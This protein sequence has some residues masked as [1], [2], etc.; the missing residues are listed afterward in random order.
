MAEMLRNRLIIRRVTTMRAIRNL[1]N[2]VVGYKS[3]CSHNSGS[4]PEVRIFAIS[5]YG[6]ELA[7][8]L[9]SEW[10]LEHK[11]MGDAVLTDTDFI[12]TA[13]MAETKGE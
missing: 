6:E 3:E 7:Y 8:E 11:C 2:Q 12:E 10:A 1:K 9:A 5:K 13:K 4:K